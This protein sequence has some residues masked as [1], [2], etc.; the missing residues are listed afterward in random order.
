MDKMALS[1]PCSLPLGCESK[2][3]QSQHIFIKKSLFFSCPTNW[4]ISR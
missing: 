3:S 2:W 4:S 1:S